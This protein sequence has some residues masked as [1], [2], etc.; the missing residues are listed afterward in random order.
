[1]RCARLG[2]LPLRLSGD[3]FEGGD[4]VCAAASC[5]SRRLNS[6]R[7]EFVV[8]VFVGWSLIAASRRISY[9]L[10]TKRNPSQ[11]SKFAP[12]DVDCY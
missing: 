3:G 12:P 1:M 6:T 11:K 4:E 9:N 2:G 7:V 8:G 5:V 10:V